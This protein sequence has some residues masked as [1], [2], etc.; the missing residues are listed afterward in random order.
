MK[1]MCCPHCSVPYKETIPLESE[2]I[3]NPFNDEYRLKMVCIICEGEWN[4]I[5]KPTHD[6]KEE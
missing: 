3:Y 6:E 1:D 2:P 4:R 5:Y